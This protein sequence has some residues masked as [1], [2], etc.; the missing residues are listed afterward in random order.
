MVQ[1]SSEVVLVS[2]YKL[3]A[4]NSS[5]VPVPYRVIKPTTVAEQ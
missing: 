4:L 1:R 3:Y 2:V 5:Q